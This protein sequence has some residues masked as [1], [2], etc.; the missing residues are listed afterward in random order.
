[1]K[2]MDVRWGG[3]DRY[4]LGWKRTPT[5]GT[6]MHVDDMYT[7]R[8]RLIFER[9]DLYERVEG[10]DL[11]HLD[12]QGPI[13]RYRQAFDASG[14]SELKYNGHINPYP[15]P[16]EAQVSAPGSDMVYG[17]IGGVERTAFD[18]VVDAA[19]KLRS[20]LRQADVPDVPR[21]ERGENNQPSLWDM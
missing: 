19:R 17:T 3:E 6:R 5:A 11:T 9:G 8:M 18:R 4:L 12:A 13:Q 14:I 16:G 2:H 10:F 15:G 7:S 21:A 20:D 1:M